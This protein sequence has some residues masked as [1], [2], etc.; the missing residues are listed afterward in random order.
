[1]DAFDGFNGEEEPFSSGGGLVCTRFAGDINCRTGS[2]ID[3]SEY[4]SKAL[5]MEV[6]APNRDC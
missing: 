4:A 1:M 2:A 3:R 6:D 5:E